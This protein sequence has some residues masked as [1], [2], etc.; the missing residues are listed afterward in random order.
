MY[1][2]NPKKHIESWIGS[3]EFVA[4]YEREICFSIIV[5]EHEVLLSDIKQGMEKNVKD[6]HSD[7]FWPD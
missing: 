4:S 3:G 7:R 5:S 1:E 6:N 2:P